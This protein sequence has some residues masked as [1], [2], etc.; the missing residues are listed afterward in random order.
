MPVVR[1]LRRDVK[2]PNKLP[3]GE[4][5]HWFGYKCPMG[6]H[7]KSTY[8]APLVSEFFAGGECSTRA[9]VAFA[10]WWDSQTDAQAAV[11]AVWPRKEQG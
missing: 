11:D 7:P 1:V 8:P 6:L 10:G 4:A 9:V 2:R 5:F 3:I